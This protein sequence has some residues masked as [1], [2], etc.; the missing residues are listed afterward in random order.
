MFALHFSRKSSQVLKKSVVQSL[1]TL[2]STRFFYSAK[3]TNALRETRE[4]LKQSPTGI[5]N[6]ISRDGILYGNDRE[7]IQ[8][9]IEN[10]LWKFIPLVDFH[11]FRFSQPLHYS[12][13]YSNDFFVSKERSTQMLNFIEAVVFNSEYDGFDMIGP[14]GVGKSE[15]MVCWMSMCLAA[16]L[17]VVYIVSESFLIGQNKYT[18]KLEF[19]F[20]SFYFL[21]IFTLI[22]FFLFFKNA[23]YI[24]LL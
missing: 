15:L 7:K 9:M 4:K 18:N 2:C 21:F 13:F 3:K 11:K 16:D 6:H 10:N 12:C 22:Y 1:P 23:F 20:T 5:L 17:P 24:I 19:F 8:Q 14:I